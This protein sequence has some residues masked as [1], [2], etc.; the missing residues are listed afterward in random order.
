L[1]A[2]VVAFT[3]ELDNEF[4]H[5]MPHRIASQRASGEPARGPW[6]TSAVMWANCLRYLA[7][8]PD[9]MTVAEL[10]RLAR[11]PT[12]LDGMRRWGY[13]AIDG[14]GAQATLRLRAA[15]R[16]AAAAW[17]PLPD[18]IEGRWRQRIG[19]PGVDR[20]R[21]ALATFVTRFEVELP[22]CLPILRHE[23]FCDRGDVA[24]VRDQALSRDADAAISLWSLLSRTLLAFAREYEQDAR[25]SLAVTADVLRVLDPEAVH[26]ADLP[27]VSGVSKE[28]LA[29]ALKLLEKRGLVDVGSDGRRRVGRLTERG[30]RAQARGARR[31]TACE[32]H[33]R[34]RFGA[35]AVDELRAALE[36]VVVD[37]TRGGSPLFA[38]LEPYP[39][40][41]RA[42]VRPPETLPHFPMVLHRGGYPDGS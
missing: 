15:G 28:A 2:A 16:R 42:H 24:P 26:V 33:W 13:L 7:P 38:G 19:A 25:L 3:I 8:A 20:L 32:A 39:D 36:P 9:G 14:T 34:E 1:S 35:A 4:E 29:M 10:G 30:A 18:E 6:L 17:E 31:V 23:L 5:R 27:R 22:D 11:T 12:N 41:W 37:A 40:G 21:A